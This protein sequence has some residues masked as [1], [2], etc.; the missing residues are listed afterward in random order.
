MLVLPHDSLIS[1]ELFACGVHNAVL[2]AANVTAVRRLDGHL[3][4]GAELKDERLWSGLVGVDTTVS[5]HRPVLA[6]VT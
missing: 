4:V 3:G 6:I 5:I 2:L 1:V